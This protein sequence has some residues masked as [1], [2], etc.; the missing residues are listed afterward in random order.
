MVAETGRDPPE[1]SGRF[2]GEEDLPVFRLQ[3]PYRRV[4][5][6]SLPVPAALNSLK[7]VPKISICF[8]PASRLVHHV[9][10]LPVPPGR[11]CQDY[12]YAHRRCDRAPWK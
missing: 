8:T 3:I 4:S 9:R 1:S 12:S 7:Q 2:A 5:E 10:K 11:L 6:A